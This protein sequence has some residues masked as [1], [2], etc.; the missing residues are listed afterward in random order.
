MS[1][2]L[3]NSLRLVIISIIIL[4]IGLI[5]SSCSNVGRLRRIRVDGH[6][7][8]AE[9]IKI[10][11]TKK[12]LSI[13]EKMT[14]KIKWIGIPVGKAVLEVKGKEIIRGREAYRIELMARTNPIMS[15]IF[16]VRDKYISFMDVE[17]L[18]TLRHEVDRREGFYRKKAYTDF[19]QNENYAYFKNLI[20]GS[21][22]EFKIP[23]NVQD[24]LTAFY[25]LRTLDLKLGDTITYN[26]INS[27][28]KYTVYGNISKKEFIKIRGLGIYDAF[29]IKPYA[30]I[31]GKKTTRGS[32]ISYFSADSK[33]LPLI[34][35]IRSYLFTKI[36]VT[37]IDY[38]EGKQ[39]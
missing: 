1:K 25:Y 35:I 15:A 12:I 29:L 10:K 17:N 26:V 14:F 9:D 13:G 28:K 21:D 2:K 4:T 22:K 38:K 24:A 32:A 3:N 31:D 27:E 39:T 20:D 34:T 8:A 6:L 37:L 11:T 7:K 23:P 18:C 16:P 33:R 30:E 36:V 19:Y 5:C